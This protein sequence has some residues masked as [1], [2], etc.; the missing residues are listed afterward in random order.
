MSGG[1]L[2]YFYSDMESH[3]GDFGDMELD[4]LVKDLAELFHAREWFL[5]GDTGSGNWNEAR[6]AFKKKWF[7][8]GSRPERIEKYLD[9]IREELMEQFGISNKYCKN[10]KNWTPDDRD[11][12]EEYGKCG[13][14]K[15][16]LTHRSDSCE[17]FEGK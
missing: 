13:F 14:H 11:N 8:E 12:Y 1:S 5:S 9:E 4:D 16:C 17:K 7:G 3:V 2:N 10:C 6:D 15:T